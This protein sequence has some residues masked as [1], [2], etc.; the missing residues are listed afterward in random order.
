MKEGWRREHD[1]NTEGEEREKGN[2]K[3][4]EQGRETRERGLKNL[5]DGN[6]E[7]DER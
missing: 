6:R 7:R 5:W 2:F 4:M 3:G 1:D